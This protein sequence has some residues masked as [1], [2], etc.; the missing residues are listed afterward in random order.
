M[1]ALS[2]PS[3]TATKNLTETLCQR[4]VRQGTNFSIASITGLSCATV[5]FLMRMTSKLSFPCVPGARIDADLWYDDLALGLAMI[6]LFPISVLSNVLNSLGIGKDV[7]RLLEV[8]PERPR[9]KTVFLSN[10]QAD[11]EASI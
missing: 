7:C 1:T 4:P 9:L 5:A 11:R 8:S 10:L 3:T 2:D 6:M